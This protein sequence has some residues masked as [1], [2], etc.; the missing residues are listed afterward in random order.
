MK[1]IYIYIIFWFILLSFFGLS[2]SENIS[3]IIKHTSIKNME[4]IVIDDCDYEVIEKSDN[5]EDFIIKDILKI[6]YVGSYNPGHVCGQPQINAFFKNI[7]NI[8]IL[9]GLKVD[10]EGWYLDTIKNFTSK[11]EINSISRYVIKNIKKFN[12]DIIYV[13]DDAAFEYIGIPLSKDYPVFFSGINQS[14]EDYCFKYKGIINENNMFGVDEV[15]NIESLYT[16]FKISNIFPEKWYFINDNTD[17]SKYIFNNLQRQL[18][19]LRIPYEVFEVNNKKEYIDT[20]TKLNSYKPGVI[21]VNSHSL[22]SEYHKKNIDS[23]SLSILAVIYNKIHLSFSINSELVKYGL[24]IVNGPDY[25]KKGTLA[26]NILLNFLSNKKKS[27][28]VYRLNSDITINYKR[29]SELEYFR[30]LLKNINKIDNIIS[31][32]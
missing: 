1:N 10:I 21:V 18:N 2:Y 5:T 23:I 25:Y 9:Y 3:P 8:D 27:H 24:S 32:Y 14:F 15:T 4:N 6:Y 11:Q 7:E 28:Q 19:D 30:G 26:G 20:I 29:I 17:V 13:T 22:Y 16:L 31:T 12:P